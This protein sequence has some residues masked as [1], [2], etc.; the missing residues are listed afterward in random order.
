MVFSGKGLS[1]ETFQGQ[2][3]EASLD[4]REGYRKWIKAIAVIFI[5][6]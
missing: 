1:L 4:A 6:Y 5:M 2:S 3:N